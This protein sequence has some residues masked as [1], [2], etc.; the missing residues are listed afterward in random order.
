MIKQALSSAPTLVNPNFNKDFILYAYGA[1]DTISA[2]LVQKNDEGQEQPVAFFSKGMDDYEQRYT[3]FEKHVLAAIKA[4]KKFKH[5]IANNIVHLMVAHPSVKEFLL[6]KDVN[7]KR[8]GW[9]TRV[10]EYDVQI[11]VTKLVRGKGLCA[12][13]ANE[14]ESAEIPHKSDDS[15]ID[16]VLIF[17]SAT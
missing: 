7:E 9:I 11:H 16:M 4:L 1:T 17:N 10:M 5:L 6:S 12:Q 8:A 2:M 3:F 13:L 15:Q 14:E